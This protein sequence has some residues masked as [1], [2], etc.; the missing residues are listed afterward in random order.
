MKRDNFIISHDQEYQT[1]ICDGCKREFILLSV[2]RYSEKT[3]TAIEQQECDC[4][5][6][7]RRDMDETTRVDNQ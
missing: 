5:P 3:G 7:C 1:I 4:C 2:H 6:F